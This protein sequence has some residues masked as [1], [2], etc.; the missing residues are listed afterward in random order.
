MVDEIGFI[1]NRSINY[2]SVHDY[3][4]VHNSGMFMKVG[5]IGYYELVLLITAYK[6]KQ[7]ILNSNSKT[8]TENLSFH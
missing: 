6:Y 7:M 2:K 1:H 5:L 8:L 4:V 3:K